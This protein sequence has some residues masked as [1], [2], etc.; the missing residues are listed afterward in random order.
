MR[1]RE[2]RRLPDI[3]RLFLRVP[4]A[5][6]RP[7]RESG[8]LRSGFCQSVRDWWWSTPTRGYVC[9]VCYLLSDSNKRSGNL[10]I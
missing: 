4:S 8:V 10:R 2:P 9:H 3:S 7:C 5:K 6:P 1:L